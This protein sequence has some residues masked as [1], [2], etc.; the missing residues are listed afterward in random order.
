MGIEPHEVAQVIDLGFKTQLAFPLLPVRKYNG[1]LPDSR[2]CLHN[3]FQDDFPA[4][5]IELCA[6]QN[7]FR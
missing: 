5:G 3:H 1:N 2:F 6:F 4:E 7:A